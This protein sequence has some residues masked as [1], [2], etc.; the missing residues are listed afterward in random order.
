[1]RGSSATPARADTEHVPHGLSWGSC[2]KRAAAVPGG[3]CRSVLP[4]GCRRSS[5]ERATTSKGPE[6]QQVSEWRP[7][8]L[9]A[10]GVFSQQHRPVVTLLM[11]TAGA[12]TPSLISTAHIIYAF[13]HCVSW[14]PRLRVTVWSW[15]AKHR[16]TFRIYKCGGLHTPRQDFQGKGD[17]SL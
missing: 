3:M 10:N 11:L 17:S 4:K 8:V 7:R 13:S 1:M 16:I 2:S 5:A 14:C 9:N 15:P 6:Q 12:L